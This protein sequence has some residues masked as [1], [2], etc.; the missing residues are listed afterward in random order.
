MA[1]GLTPAMVTAL[2]QPYIRPLY[3]VRLVTATETLY[4]WN[5]PGTITWNAQV[6]TGLGLFGSIKS[7]PETTTVTA[8]GIVLELSGVPIAMVGMALNELKP[9]RD[10]DVWFGLL[11]TA[12]AVIADPYLSYKGLTDAGKLD[13]DGETATIQVQV[14]SRLI[15]LNRARERR[16]TDAD[17]K[18]YFPNDQ[19]FA[20]VAELQNA[21]VHWGQ[22]TALPRPTPTP[23]PPRRGDDD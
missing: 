22:A 2:S 17:Q 19:G 15:D 3:F 11:N 18:R 1:R 23:Q 12:G 7:I 13:D 8:V 4:L 10:C 6:W 20:F 14:E 16:Y 9:Y 21:V 5:G